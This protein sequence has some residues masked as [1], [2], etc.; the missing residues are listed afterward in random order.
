LVQGIGRVPARLNYTSAYLLCLDN[1]YSGRK[2]ERE[3]SLNYTPV[4]QAIG[5][6]LSWFRE[7][8]YC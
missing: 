5:H 6:A 8:H 1:Y 7:H 4:E 3:L 2:S